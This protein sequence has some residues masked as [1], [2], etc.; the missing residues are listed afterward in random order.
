M[1][2]VEHAE[3]ATHLQFYDSHW[4]TSVQMSSIS[5]FIAVKLSSGSH[6]RQTTSSKDLILHCAVNPCFLDM[7][8]V[9][10]SLSLSSCC[11]ACR[12][13]RHFLPGFSTTVS[14]AGL[15]GKKQML[16]REV[17][18]NKKALKINMSHI[19]QRLK[20]AAQASYY[21]WLFEQCP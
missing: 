18:Q 12:S 15:A 14:Y 19:V 20:F 7:E 5:R 17:L 8:W 16:D 4:N 13:T 2:H 11:E 9:L 10:C 1:T 21:C 3:K 6:D